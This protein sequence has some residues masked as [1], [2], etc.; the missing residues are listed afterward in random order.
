M[1]TV[2]LY[3]LAADRFV[4]ERN[5]LARE[6]RSAGR[7]AE[8]EAVAALRKPS[9]AAQ[10]VNRLARSERRAFTQLF[11][12]GDALIRAQSDLLA[13]RADGRALTQA[14]QRER[15]LVDALVSTASEHAELTSS[16]RD[17]VSETLHAAALDES[18]REPVAAGRL[19]RELRHVG[20]GAVGAD[21]AASPPAKRSKRDQPEDRPDAKRRQAERERTEARQRAKAAEAAADKQVQRAAKAVRAAEQGHQRATDALRQAD[22]ELAAARAQAEAETA[23]HRAA[24]AQLE[25]L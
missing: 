6:L 3:G 11:K 24:Q 2:Q 7:P 22:V 10:V 12:A 1:D 19:E 15:T 8:A 23:L 20:L 13:G 16:V 17:R 21:I 14:V 4:P 18:A 5:A 25:S 9:L